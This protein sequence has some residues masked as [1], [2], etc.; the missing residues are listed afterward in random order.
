MFDADVPLTE[1]FPGVPTPT[2]RERPPVSPVRVT[3]LDNGARV[4]SVDTGDRVSSV[5]LFVRAGSRYESAGA[6][7]GVCSLLEHMAFRGSARRSKFLQTR[8]LEKTGASFGASASREVL[9]YSA[10]GMR[11]AAG[12]LVA[13]ITEAA[14]EPMV[15]GATQGTA[16]WDAARAEIK[17]QAAAM[18][19]H[20]QLS[21]G[22]AS[23]ELNELLHATAYNSVGLGTLLALVFRRL[24]LY[25]GLPHTL[26]R[27]ALVAGLHPKRESLYAWLRFACRTPLS[28]GVALLPTFAPVSVVRACRAGLDGRLPRAPRAVV[29]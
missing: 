14:L 11:A 8:A 2:P 21:A 16:A 27:P 28:P 23:V 17:T 13:E 1:S 12:T 4:A 6:N 20:P 29:R 3:K 26:F 18:A 24:R 5:G 15:M 22:D 7:T 10:E 19:E 25:L 9:I